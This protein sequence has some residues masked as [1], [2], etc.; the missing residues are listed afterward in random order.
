MDVRAGIGRGFGKVI[1]LGE[2][3]VVHG[4]PAIAVGLDR[5][6]KA[7]VTPLDR[8][9]SRLTI[10]EWSASSTDRADL[11]LAFDALLQATGTREPVTVV[12]ET[13]LVPGAGLGCSAALGVA[14]TRA[15]LSASGIEEGPQAIAARA[16]A[17]EKV[18]HGT[19]SGIDTTVAA[20]GGCLLYQRRD[21]GPHFAP[22]SLGAPLHLAIGYTGHPASTRT[23]VEAVAKLRERKADVVAKT[24][25]GIEALVRNARL[26]LEA[27]DRQGLGRLLDL[28]QMLLAGLF[29]STPEIET[30]CTLAREAGAL[31]AKLTGAGGGG[32]VIALVENS[33]EPILEAWSRAGFGGFATTIAAQEAR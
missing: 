16:L 2:H 30:M 28:G 14:M 33:P 32:C 8:G 3:A 18:F 15:L 22:V 26:A 31:G 23:M 20:H 17:W 10:G 11:G 27:G 19:P 6:A 12:A 7:T 21:D 1:L 25:E 29:V 13:D 4:V 5:G 9:P 24:F